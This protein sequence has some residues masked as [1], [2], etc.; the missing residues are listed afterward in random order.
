MH[1]EFVSIP[2][3][4]TFAGLCNPAELDPA[5]E[6]EVHTFSAIEAKV[7]TC[8]IPPRIRDDEFAFTLYETIRPN[9]RLRQNRRGGKVRLVPEELRAV[10]D[11][12]WEV[13][14]GT[15][16]MNN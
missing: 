8:M 16:S 11:V 4:H 1:D 3:V 6:S 5:F 9:G 13:A 2:E 10:R 14:C 15:Q 7:E 12:L